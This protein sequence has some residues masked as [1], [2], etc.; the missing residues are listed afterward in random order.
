[1]T[2]AQVNSRYDDAVDTGIFR[3]RQQGSAIGVV[4]WEVEMAMRV[5]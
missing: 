5:D 3:A 4:A 1:M 2:A